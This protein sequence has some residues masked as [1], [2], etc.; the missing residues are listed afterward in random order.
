MTDTQGT[1]NDV[2]I[3][4]Y[5]NKEMVSNQCSVI[6]FLPIINSQRLPGSVSTL[7]LCVYMNTDSRWES[8]FTAIAFS[9]QNS[10]VY[11]LFRV[12]SA[13]RFVCHATLGK[14]FGLRPDRM[15][16]PF[17]NQQAAEVGGLKQEVAGLRKA[18]QKSFCDLQGVG[19]APSAAHGS[20]SVS[21]GA[22]RRD[23]GFTSPF[24]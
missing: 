8:L 20:E 11:Q 22:S 16:E 24:I 6:E 2:R 17:V 13:T 15:A 18:L 3:T 1:G 23:M 21:P 10:M 7:V 14:Q 5:I 9:L 12:Q 19:S 4:G